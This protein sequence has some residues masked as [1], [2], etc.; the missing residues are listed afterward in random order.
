MEIPCFKSARFASVVIA[1]LVSSNTLFAFKYIS[2]SSDTFSDNGNSLSVKEICPA[3]S[4]TSFAAETSNFP[5][6][7]S[8]A[9]CSKF[10]TE[11]SI[12]LDTRY[13]I[14]SSV[15]SVTISTACSACAVS[16]YSGRSMASSG[17][18]PSKT[19]EAIAFAMSFFSIGNCNPLNFCI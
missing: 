2:A 5:S 12:W 11:S 16:E 1:S 3:S 6:L 15:A 19:A 10:S 7:R 14:S 9:A 18:S 13:A 4:M 17:R 8:L